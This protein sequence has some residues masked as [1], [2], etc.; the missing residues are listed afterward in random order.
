MF[1]V[2]QVTSTYSGRKGCACGCRGNYTYTA[3]EH[4]PNYMTGNEGVNRKAAERMAAKVERM[5]RDPNSDVQKVHV[6]PDGDWFA[7]DMEHDRTYTVYFREAPKA[8]PMAA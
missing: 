5:V 8:E 7:V 2:N 1:N 6:D 3:P 4:R